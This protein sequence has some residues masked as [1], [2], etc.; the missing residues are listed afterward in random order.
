MR[1]G[2]KGIVQ[3]PDSV[4]MGMDDGKL[5]VLHHPSGRTELRDADWV[6]LAVPQE[7]LEELYFALADSGLEV[8]RAGD[9]VAPRRAHAAVIEGQRVGTAL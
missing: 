6:V 8:H 7:P 5:Q 1:A 9:C 3:T 4:V 2:A